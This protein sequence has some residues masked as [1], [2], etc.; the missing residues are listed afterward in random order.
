[1]SRMP[2]LALVAL[3]AL[4]TPLAHPQSEPSGAVAQEVRYQSDRY[5]D[6]PPRDYSRDNFLRAQ[7]QHAIGRAVPRQAGRNPIRV[8]VRGGQVHLIG[9]VRDAQTRALAYRVAREVPGVRRVSV[10]RLYASRW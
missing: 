4:Y 5:G 10:R 3:L 2:L 7:V 1:M 9:K 6:L 8:E